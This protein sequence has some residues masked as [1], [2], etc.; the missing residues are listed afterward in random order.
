MVET[1][2]DKHVSKKIKSRA[3]KLRKMMK[4]KFNIDI[5][6]EDLLSA[7]PSEIYDVPL[8][9]REEE[10]NRRMRENDQQMNIDE[11]N[12]YEN[13]ETLNKNSKSQ[14]CF[15]C[16]L[17]SP[18][19]VMHSFLKKVRLGSPIKFIAMFCTAIRLINCGPK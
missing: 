2:G 11:D 10:V 4:D 17:N 5:S 7:L 12:T 3:E 13:E 6:H 14:I 1:S 16:G 18:S 15:K 8:V 19:S 9:E